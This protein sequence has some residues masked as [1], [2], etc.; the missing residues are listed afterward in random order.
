MTLVARVLQAA[1]GVYFAA[2]GVLHFILPAGLPPQMAW[3]YDVPGGLHLVS[4]S[5]EVA[6]G[7]V[8]LLGL[9]VRPVRPLVRPAALGLIAV[10]ILAAMWHATRGE[11]QMIVS[12]AVVAALLGLVV[13]VAPSRT[14]SAPAGGAPTPL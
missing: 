14:A 8:L 7:A 13:A 12:N 5:A 2:T 4:G 3:M 9:V 6:A 10:M 11:A 1:L